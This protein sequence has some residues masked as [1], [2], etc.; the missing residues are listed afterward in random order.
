M[1]HR[2]LYYQTKF[3]LKHFENNFNTIWW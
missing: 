1:P 3:A 2:L